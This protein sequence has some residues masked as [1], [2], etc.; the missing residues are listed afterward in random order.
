MSQLNL[1]PKV[2]PHG[3]WKIKVMHPFLHHNLQLI[4]DLHVL[5]PRQLQLYQLL[6]QK[7]VLQKSELLYLHFLNQKSIELNLQSNK[8]HDAAAEILNQHQALNTLFY[9]SNHLPCDPVI[10]RLHQ[11]LHLEPFLFV[12]Q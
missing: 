6:L 1:I 8:Y 9:L 11:A 10:A 7:L 4:Y 5:L 3:E 2:N 12:T